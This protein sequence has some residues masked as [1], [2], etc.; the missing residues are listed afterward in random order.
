M[1]LLK[2][3]LPVISVLFMSSGIAQ[4][5][6]A[7]IL[8]TTTTKTFSFE[9]EGVNQ[10]YELKVY[11]TRK[12]EIKLKKEDKDKVNQNRVKTPAYV[13]KLILINNEKDK[14]YDRY[15]VLKY[16]KS[17]NDSFELV[18]TAKGFAVNVDKNH[19]E[20]IMGEGVY[21]THNNHHDYFTV[22]EFDKIN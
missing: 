16:K 18:Q 14:S 22:V 15:I 6:S 12:Y 20:Y 8:E 19:L 11:E 3:L 4:E 9:K 10:Q 13:S 7:E 1:K 5:H 17:P 2:L 21:R